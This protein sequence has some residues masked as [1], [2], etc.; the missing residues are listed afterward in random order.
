[1]IRFLTLLTGLCLLV[2][3]FASAEDA[4]LDFGGDH[5]AA[6]QVS[7]AQ[8]PIAH[9]AFMAGYDVS[10]TAPVASDAHL[11]GYNINVS[12]DTG[13]NL[14]AAG[15]SVNVTGKVGGDVTAIGNIVS[16]RAPASVAGN[17]RLA[18][19]N[20]VIAG[21]V[22]GSALVSAQNL[23]L[24]GAIAGDFSF[25]GETIT[26]APGARVGGMVSIKAPKEIAVPASVA[27]AD[28]VTFELLPAP[29]Y[30]NAASNTAGSV[31]GHFWPAFW[32]AAIWTLLLF[33]VGAALIGLMPRAV[34]ALQVAAET[35][36]FRKL[37][38]GALSLAALI[39][40][41][42]VFAMTIIG[43]LLLPFVFLFVVITCSLGYL[44]GTF[45]VGLKLSNAFLRID[46]NLKRVI[47][48]AV[49]LV[50]AALLGAI[51][52]LGWLINL[53]LLAFGLGAMAVIVMVRW[54][55][56]DAA[57]LQMADAA[58]EGKAS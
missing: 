29:D 44:A 20:V 22:T 14:Y 35:R 45:F 58:T 53:L 16:L 49:A 6:G 56:R 4:A 9:D 18:G 8:L 13:G 54:S 17:L 21:P 31:V 50:I 34:R 25:Y 46:T 39:G 36:P 10:L 38:L 28:R 5:Y 42:P 19:A 27:P 3:T 26:F 57:R 41:V 51:P 2:P 15:F 47:V 40:L 48:L 55:A 52:F 33:V 30:V 37:G 12:A 1:M 24:D 23:T 32:G 7:A 11:A 43:I